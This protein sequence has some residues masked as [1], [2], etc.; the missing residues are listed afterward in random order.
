MEFLLY[1][2]PMFTAICIIGVLGIIGCLITSIIFYVGYL[3]ARD[4]SQEKVEVKQF[5]KNSKF[6]GKLMVVCSVFVILSAPVAHI[7]STFKTVLLYRGIT[8]ENV[9]RIVDSTTRIIEMAEKYVETK[10]KTPE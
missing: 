10:I 9:E 7:D 6:F 1:L 3:E 8:S 5:L 4:K 2:S